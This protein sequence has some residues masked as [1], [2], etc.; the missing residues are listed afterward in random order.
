MY[1]QVSA[2]NEAENNAAGDGNNIGR[3]E[4]SSRHCKHRI[5]RNSQLIDKSRSINKENI[6]PSVDQLQLTHSSSANSQADDNAIKVVSNKFLI[7]ILADKKVNSLNNSHIDFYF[8]L[9]FSFELLNK[10]SSIGEH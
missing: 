9:Y 3:G 4:L 6:Q 1:Y 8:N 7:C 2:K 5:S 10:F